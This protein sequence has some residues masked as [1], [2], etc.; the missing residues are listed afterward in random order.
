MET[1]MISNKLS[2]FSYCHTRR[3]SARNKVQKIPETKFSIPKL[4][5]KSLVAELNYLN[6]YTRND[7]L[8]NSKINK[9]SNE[10]VKLHLIMEIVSDR[11]EMHKNIGIQRDNWN[12]LLLSSVNMMTLSASSMVGL[13]AVASA[14]TGAEASL[15]ALKVS[16][17]ILYMAATGLL[18]F[19]NKV[20]PSQLAEEQRNA[21]RFFNQLQGELRTKLALGNFNEDDVNEAIEKVLALDKAFPLPLLGS[22]L[23][24]FPETVKPAVWWPQMKTRKHER[25]LQGKKNNGWNLRLE[26]EMKKIV[27]VLKNKDIENCM[28]LSKRVL[29]LNKLLSFSGPILTCFAAFG[30]VFLGSV[31]ASW[32]MM[33]GIIC[34]AMASVVN[35]IE[36]GGQVGMVFE[37]YR[38]TSGLLKLME[39]TIELNINEEDYYKRENGE[40]LEI[41]V[42]LQ[43]GRSLS[44]LRQFSNDDDDVCEEFANKLF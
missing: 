31:N 26:E 38:S 30:S 43:L 22:M 35:T 25:N 37:F 34:G 12:S 36:H 4:R 13:A 5:N 1:S 40:L 39:E 20:Q 10:V 24:K 17:T 8:N 41:K 3:I 14:S 15:L 16:S 7:D 9:N 19:M 21:V 32:P 27:M 2:S 44:E 18:L 28:K 6:N 33:L 42:A 11:L 29:K 23:E